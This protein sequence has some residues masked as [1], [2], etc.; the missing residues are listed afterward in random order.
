MIKKLILFCLTL[1]LLIQPSFSDEEEDL[2]I[3]LDKKNDL[4]G[5]EFYNELAK[6]QD[7]WAID[8]ITQIRETDDEDT[9]LKE[10]KTSSALEYAL[11]FICL[12]DCKLYKS[13]TECKMICMIPKTLIDNSSLGF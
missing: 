8:M 7:K 13:M 12:N 1:L 11:D 2:R 3:L 9:E 4:S 6:L 10:Q 5:E